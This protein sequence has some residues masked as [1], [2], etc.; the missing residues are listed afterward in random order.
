M[1]IPRGNSIMFTGK[2]KLGELKLE[3]AAEILDNGWVKTR[4]GD[5]Y[6]YYPPTLIKWI[7]QDAI[8]GRSA[9]GTVRRDRRSLY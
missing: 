7:A 5:T 9:V 2:N 3:Y 8:I 4:Q 6:F 1:M